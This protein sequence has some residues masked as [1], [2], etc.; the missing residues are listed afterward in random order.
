M[1]KS[2]YDRLHEFIYRGGG[3]I[4]VN[5][6]AQELAQQTGIGEIVTFHEV[7]SRDLKFHQC[8][9]T[10]LNYIWGFM[11]TKF[12]QTVPQS[13]FYEWL[14]HLKGEYDVIFEFADGTK[15]VEYES[16]S[17]GKMSQKRFQEYIKEQLPWIYENV[18]GKMYEGE[19]YDQIIQSVEDEFEK[20]LS[21]L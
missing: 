11:P 5:S 2:E 7:T 13:K 15:L 3:F 14:K 20:F 12:Q 21:K 1:K 4:P 19:R 9:F 16:L 10:L 17:F 6:N 8:Y 18:I